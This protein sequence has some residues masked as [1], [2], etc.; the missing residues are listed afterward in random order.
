VSDPPRLLP[1]GDSALSVVFGDT[2]DAETNARVR[3]LDARLLACPFPGFREAIP[4]HSTLLVL[5][6][7][8]T[9]DHATAVAALQEGAAQARPVDTDARRAVR[10]LSVVYGGEHGADLQAVAE[11]CEMTTEEVVEHHT[12][13]ELTAFML[14]FSPGFAYLGLLPPAL[15]RPRRAEPRERVPA[16]SVAIA[17]PFTAVY[18][19][20][21]AGGWH[22]IGRTAQLLFDP[23]A[24]PPSLI[25]PGDRVRF[26]AV[27]TLFPTAS[28]APPHQTTQNEAV[29]EVREPGL[30]TTVQDAGRPGRRRLGVAP[31]GALDL[32]ALFAANRALGNPDGAAALECTLTGPTLRFLQGCEIAI[33]GADLGAVLERSDLGAWPVP[34]GTPVRAR[35]GNVLRFAE[36]RAGVRAYLAIAGGIRTPEVLGSRSACV[37]GGFPGLAGRALRAGDFL[38]GGLP[39]PAR[40]AVISARLPESGTATLRVVLG[41]QNDVFGAESCAAFLA[42]DYTVS[43]SSDRAGWRLEGPALFSSGPG[44][45]ASEGMIPGSIQVP[46]WGRPIVMGP[47]GPTTGGYPKIATVISV[48]LPRLAQLVPGEGHVR[49]AAVSVEEAQALLKAAARP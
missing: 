30:F 37:V 4:A 48:D 19:T 11:A 49:F 27:D 22:L 39:R 8:S 26:R 1:V 17:G 31:A 28:V 7:P 43:P 38:Q 5:Y 21:S 20:A 47:D 45:I 34:L 13:H 40:G 42:A 41:P 2:I 6:D 23:G 29:L 12:A 14:G 33:A 25:L 10:V 16:G 18:P 44:E 24:D 9:C 32:P 46:P 36:R 15:Q 3:A 35:A